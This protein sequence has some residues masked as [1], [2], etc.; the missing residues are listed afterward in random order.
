MFHDVMYTRFHRL[1]DGELESWDLYITPIDW[2][3]RSGDNLHS[4]LDVNPTFERL[5]EPFTISPGVVLPPGDYRFTRFAGSFASATRRRVSVNVSFRWG[6]YWSGDAEVV[7]LAATYRVP[8]NF[9]IGVNTNQ[10]F[11]RLP[12]GDFTAR[13][14]TLNT[15]F[16][17]SPTLSFFTLVQYDNRSRNLGWQSRARWTITPGSDLFASFQQGWIREDAA[18]D[19]RFAAQ[20]RK[21]SVKLQYSLRF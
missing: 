16:S 17:A 12:Q 4:V 9:S 11:A 7:G 19:R 15:S 1:D 6:S 2:H 3:F 5:F 21:T 18:G 14:H 13:I 20:D 8:P 10:T